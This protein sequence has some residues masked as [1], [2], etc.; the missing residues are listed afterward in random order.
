MTDDVRAVI[1]KLFDRLHNMRTIRAMPHHKQQQKAHETL[2][3]YA[4]LA[5]RLGHLERQE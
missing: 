4:P 2:S 5:N 1:I 3:V